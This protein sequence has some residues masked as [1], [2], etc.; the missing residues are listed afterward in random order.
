MAGGNEWTISRFKRNIKS[1]SYLVYYRPYQGANKGKQV[2][3]S[4]KLG[5]GDNVILPLMEFLSPPW[6]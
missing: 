2:G 4:T 1:N 3:F 6:S 5:L